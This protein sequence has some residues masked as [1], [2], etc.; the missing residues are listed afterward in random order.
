MKP[1]TQNCERMAAKRLLY[2]A[3]FVISEAAPITSAEEPVG[4]IDWA[5]TGE[6][7]VHG[8]DK[9]ASVVIHLE[10]GQR[11]R[12]STKTLPDAGGPR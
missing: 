5:A 4:R 1:N 2:D 6:E 9:A 8:G 11:F 12:V 3:L 7:R 10:N